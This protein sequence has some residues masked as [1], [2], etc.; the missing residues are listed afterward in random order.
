MVPMLCVTA[1][2]LGRH[3]GI[4]SEAQGDCR[5]PVHRDEK[6][7][8]LPWLLGSGNPLYLDSGEQT[9]QNP[10]LIIGRVVGKS[11]NP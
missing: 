11:C 6:D 9:N 3:T 4:P 2:K 7:H 5:Y 10:R 1:I 8:R